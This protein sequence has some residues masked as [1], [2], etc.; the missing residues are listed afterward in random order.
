MFLLVKF[1]IGL[2]KLHSFFWFNKIIKY[3]RISCKYKYNEIMLKNIINA[4]MKWLVSRS[5]DSK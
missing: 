1:G 4:C 5:S 3:N 2:P